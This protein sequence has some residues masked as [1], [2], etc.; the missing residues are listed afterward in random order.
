MS[1]CYS[2]RADASRAESDAHDTKK[3]GGLRGAAQD[4]VLRLQRTLQARVRHAEPPGGFLPTTTE[5]DFSRKC[6]SVKQKEALCLLLCDLVGTESHKCS[7]LG[8]G[9]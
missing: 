3:D 6:S 5:Q 4:E 9:H 8:G 7:S 1:V 2:G